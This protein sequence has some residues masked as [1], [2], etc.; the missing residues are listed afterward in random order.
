M[1]RLGDDVNLGNGKN[2]ACGASDSHF[3]PL[4][5]SARAFF[6]LPH[7]A[8]IALPDQGQDGIEQKR[9]LSGS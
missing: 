8:L 3:S 5:T 6:F 1:A 2:R 9:D 7:S 4:Y